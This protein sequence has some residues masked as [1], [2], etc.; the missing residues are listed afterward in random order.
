ME[1]VEQIKEI[2]VDNGQY[3]FYLQLHVFKKHHKNLNCLEISSELKY[4]YVK[5]ENLFFKQAQFAKY[6]SKLLILQVRYFHRLIY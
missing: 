6:I 1:S 2:L 5:Y 4:K 3:Y